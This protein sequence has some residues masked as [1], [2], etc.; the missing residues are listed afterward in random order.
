MGLKEKQRGTV[1]LRSVS[2]C[3]SFFLL[4]VAVLSFCVRVCVFV[5]FSFDDDDEE[6][7]EDRIFFKYI[8]IYIYI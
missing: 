3:V 7:K 2:V 4:H 8:Y 6:D 5:C 1:A